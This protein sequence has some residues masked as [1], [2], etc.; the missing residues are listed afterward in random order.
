MTDKQKELARSLAR[1]IKD[2]ARPPGDI[3]GAVFDDGKDSAVQIA[4]SLKG[5]KSGN[6]WQLSTNLR[7]LTAAVKR[8]AGY[9]SDGQVKLERIEHPELK[10]SYNRNLRRQESPGHRRGVTLVHVRIPRQS[11]AETSR[12]T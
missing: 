9:F 12:S 2:E 8:A 10:R 3:R 4:V 6:A 1:K 11:W 7:S 5:E